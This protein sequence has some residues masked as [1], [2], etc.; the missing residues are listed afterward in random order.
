MN[1]QTI[2]Y[3]PIGVIHSPFKQVKGTPIQNAFARD[4]DGVVEV[5]D[6]FAEG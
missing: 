6:E 4:A 5:F 3:Q 1:R 2:T